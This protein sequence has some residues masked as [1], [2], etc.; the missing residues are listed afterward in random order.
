MGDVNRANL[1]PKHVPKLS[2]VE[3]D[4]IPLIDLSPMNMLG[5]IPEPKGIKGLVKKLGNT[6]RDWELCKVI[7]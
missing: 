7:K 2:I 3:G 4:D 6:C 5:N 1:D